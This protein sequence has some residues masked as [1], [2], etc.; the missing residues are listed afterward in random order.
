[1][2]YELPMVSEVACAVTQMM[3]LPEASMEINCETEAAASSL[4]PEDSDST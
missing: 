3:A 2:D 4:L 1:M